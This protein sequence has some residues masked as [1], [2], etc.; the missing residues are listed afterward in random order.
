M[1]DD[2]LPLS[3]TPDGVLCARGAPELRVREKAS[4]LAQSFDGSV[5]QRTTA[6]GRRAIAPRATTSARLSLGAILLPRPDREHR[7]VTAHRLGAGDATFTLASCQ[8][9]EGW[10]QPDRLRQQF[11][12][13]SRI[14]AAVPVWEVSVPWGPPFGA[15]LA[16]RTIEACELMS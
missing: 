3:L 1:T 2:V 6:D 14:V 15:D 10:T 8:R 16:R 13:I 11:G 5:P 12:D 7:Q 9:I 4:V